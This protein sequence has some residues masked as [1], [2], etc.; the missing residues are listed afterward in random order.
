MPHQVFLSHAG[1]D[2]RKAAALCD[3]LEA[4]G[5]RCWIAPRDIPGGAS[6]A[7]AIV[8]AIETTRLL[9]FL[10]SGHAAES[11]HVRSELERAFNNGIVI[12]PVR[13]E[14]VEITSELQYF[15][16]TAQWLDVFEGDF[17]Q[18]L[19]GLVKAIQ[20]ALAGA[21]IPRAVRKERRRLVLKW[22]APALGLL[23]IGLALVWSGRDPAPPTDGF[24][25]ESNTVSNT[26]ATADAA[27]TRERINSV[28]GQKYLLIP[29]GRFLMGCSAGDSECEDDENPSHWVTLPKAFWLGQTEVTIRA[30]R[31]Y[32]RTIDRNVSM[33]QDDLPIT[34][35]DRTEAKA[36]CNWAGG[37]LPTE[38][39]WEYAARAGQP[40]SRSGPLLEIGWVDENS[41]Q[42]VHLVAQKQPN[43]FDVYDM[44]GN[45][46]EWVFDRYYN[47]YYEEE[48]GAVP[49]EPV[50]P[51]ATG[52]VR[53]GSWAYGPAS[54][55]VSNRTEME[56]DA[57]EP[58]VGFRCVLDE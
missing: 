48:P 36:F 22:S 45:V 17:E 56:T 54:A 16:S 20:A 47:R 5:V 12:L 4:A 35:V 13:I 23:V 32:A 34:G 42:T 18:E 40:E 38:A 25:N 9:V 14:D 49:D 21:P 19:P 50:T 8:R 7:G 52:I 28:D 58:F 2:A 37:R 51:N 31:N 39:E 55:R 46:A 11:R 53:G 3:A 43:A 6:Y 44:L 24:P 33:T 30:F 29:A 57:A 27:P 15:T 1:E 10:Y 26:P 41:D